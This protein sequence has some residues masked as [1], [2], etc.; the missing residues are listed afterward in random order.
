MVDILEIQDNMI[1][2]MSSHKLKI[3][4]IKQHKEICGIKLITKNYFVL[5]SKDLGKPIANK[6]IYQY[7][8]NG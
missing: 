8:K 5:Q 6:E 7:I 3:G 4:K 2:Y 1:K